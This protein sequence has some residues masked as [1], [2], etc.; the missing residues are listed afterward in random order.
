MSK[1]TFKEELKR[2]AHEELGVDIDFEDPNTNLTFEK[3]FP[4]MLRGNEKT[5]YMKSEDWSATEYYTILEC[6]YCKQ[7]FSAYYYENYFTESPFWCDHCGKKFL[8]TSN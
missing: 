4:N 7:K 5:V 8:V 2:V 3:L 1:E 6:P